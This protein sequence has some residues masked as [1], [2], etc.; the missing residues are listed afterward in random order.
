MTVPNFIITQVVLA[1]ELAGYL[2][3][4]VSMASLALDI[5]DDSEDDKEIICL[6]SDGENQEKEVVELSSS[7]NESEAWEDHEDEPLAPTGR[8]RFA[9]T[10]H[11]EDSPL[12]SKKNIS[13]NSRLQTLAS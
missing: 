4:G 6:S 3:V 12:D 8:H 10:S 5:L 9:T 1:N 11:R 7:T 2:P 13:S